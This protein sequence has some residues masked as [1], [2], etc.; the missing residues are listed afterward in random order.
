[1]IA[2]TAD[3]KKLFDL[4]ITEKD[5]QPPNDTVL[6]EDEITLV[7]ELVDLEL[8]EEKAIP[9]DDTSWVFRPTAE[10]LKFHEENK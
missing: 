4:V 3:Q 6:S 1:M 7:W 5:I 10:G 2:L 8:V 9:G